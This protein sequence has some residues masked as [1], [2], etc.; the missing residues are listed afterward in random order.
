MFSKDCASPNTFTIEYR[1]WKAAFHSHSHRKALLENFHQASTK[2]PVTE[3]RRTKDFP[4]ASF[5]SVSQGKASRLI[6]HFNKYLE[7]LSSIIYIIFF[8]FCDK[9]GVLGWI[10]SLL[11]L[12]EFPLQCNQRNPLAEDPGSLE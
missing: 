10:V 2:L 3:K 4:D 9:D 6:K 1:Q 12:L 7:V 11:N 5:S 8:P